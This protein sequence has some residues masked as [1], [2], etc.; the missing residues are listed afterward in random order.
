M[1]NLFT[2][3]QSVPALAWFFAFARDLVAEWVVKQKPCALQSPGRP[4][5]MGPKAQA[6]HPLGFTRPTISR[7]DIPP[8][9]S[10]P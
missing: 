2:S 7:T 3:D 1:G 10:H 8:S 4:T 5:I 9:E 6:L